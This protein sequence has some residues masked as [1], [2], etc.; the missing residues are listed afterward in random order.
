MPGVFADLPGYWPESKWL[1][2]AAEEAARRFRGHHHGDLPRWRAALERLPTVP[3]AAALGVSTPV[4]GADADD[5][6]GLRAMLMELHPWRKG[7]L[8]LGGVSIDAE[9]RSDWK[10]ERLAPHLDLAGARVL[11]IGCGNG[12]YGLR[13]LGAGAGLVVG[14]DPT[15]LFVMQWLA[16]RHFSGRLP[17]FVLP[18]GIEELPPGRPGFDTVFCMGVLYHR[19]DPL[20]LLERLKELLRPGGELVL[21]SL[22]L[23]P[24]RQQE[25]LAPAGRYAR[26]RNV[27]AVPGTG[28]LAGWMDQA[29]FADCR[30]VDVTATTTAEQRSTAW[31]RFDSLQQALD[32]ADR[33][34]TV[35]GHPAPVRAIFIARA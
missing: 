25:V 3:A 15:V 6:D 29:G 27:W 21:E 10:W 32:P 23:P 31:M 11:D 30:V 12:Y 18:L 16:C 28:R 13:M 9:W 24:G 4:L 8:R 34:R 2:Q 22:V 17:N 1:A 7:P 20:R 33:A 35:E 5:P 19:R 26:M 14:V